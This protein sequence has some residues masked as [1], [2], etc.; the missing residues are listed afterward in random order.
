MVKQLS[1]RGKVKFI[2]KE[3]VD[4]WNSSDSIDEVCEKTGLNKS[5]VFGK[6][7]RLREC[8]YKLKRFK[9]HS[10]E[11]CELGPAKSPTFYAPGSK[12]KIEVLRDRASQGETLWHPLD[13]SPGEA[14]NRVPV[15]NARMTD[16]KRSLQTRMSF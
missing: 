9:E 12:E 10:S 15:D 11:Y 4:A 8:G 13:A 1:S 7:F 14:I 6:T 3:F 16:W 2:N 5:Q